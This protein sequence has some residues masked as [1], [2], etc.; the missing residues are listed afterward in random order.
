M[1]ER[2]ISLNADLGE[3]PGDSVA[4]ADIITTANV[5]GGGHAGGG[6]L[7]TETIATCAHHDIQIGAHPSY[8]DRE[9]FGRTSLWTSIDHEILRASIIEQIHAVQD[10]AAL[11][12]R[13]L[14]H[15]KAHGALYNDA[16]ANNDVASFL[17][18][19][20]TSAT[21]TGTPVF[22]MPG[23]AL[24]RAARAVNVPFV[25][26]GFMDRAYE[27]SGLLVSRTVPGAVL[28]DAA[29]ATTHVLS[30]V[31]DHTVTSINGNRVA[32]NVRTV[33]VHADTPGAAVTVRT[34]RTALETQGV[35]ITAFAAPT[36]ATV[37]HFGDSAYLISDLPE[38]DL[39]AFA[40][41]ITNTVPGSV[42]RPGLDSVL[43]SFPHAGDIPV[44]EH[45]SDI[46]SG[47]GRTASTAHGTM[48]TIPV[49]YDGA[50]L[51]GIAVT[52][53][54]A[55]DDI[56]AAHTNTLYRV[57][58]IGFAPGFPYLVPVDPTTP[59][60]QLL[61]QVGRLAT[62]RTAV[63][64]GSVAIA[65]AMSAIYPSSMPGGWNLI[66]H[67]D[68]TLFDAASNNPSLLRAGDRITFKEISA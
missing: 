56:V 4:L 15:V 22:G 41:A 8:P 36:S 44:L 31:L 39:A 17:L 65:S 21:P 28:Q 43:V 59:S 51:E 29:E 57:A 23:S 12:G 33:C 48:H 26:E 25:A 1:S 27:D 2:I 67:S 53:G 18:E 60:A 37:A 24:E 9:N 58:L 68:A 62:P 13:A 32:L 11:H 20:I 19:A 35:T 7:L 61:A 45:L 34:V 40:E 63:P 5:A 64:A 50:D 47:I 54:V 3:H 42:A 38:M 66:G 14:S 6:E 55:P 52:L 30:M 46:I 49:R 16:M 10:A